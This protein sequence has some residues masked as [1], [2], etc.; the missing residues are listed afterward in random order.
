MV[1]RSHR[2]RFWYRMTPHLTRQPRYPQ[3][4][5]ATAL[6]TEMAPMNLSGWLFRISR[7]QPNRTGQTRRAI[8]LAGRRSRSRREPQLRMTVRA[9]QRLFLRRRTGIHDGPVR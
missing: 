4:P 2:S 3:H 7:D 9:Q 6:V 8:R 5:T 1:I